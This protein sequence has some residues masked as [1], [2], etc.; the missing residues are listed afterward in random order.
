M[1]KSSIVLLS[2][3]LGGMLLASCSGNSSVDSV[4][5]TSTS[6]SASTSSEAG[7]DNVT[8]SEISSEASS[9][10]SAASSSSVQSGVNEGETSMDFQDDGKE[11]K[12]VELSDSVRSSVYKAGRN[13]FRSLGRRDRQYQQALNSAKY[14]NPMMQ[15]RGH[16]KMLVI[17]VYYSDSTKTAVQRESDRET[18]YKTF[19][20]GDSVSGDTYWESVRSYYYK[21]SY[22]QLS[23]EGAVAPSIRLPKT[24]ASYSAKTDW[25]VANTI[26]ET[27]YKYLFQGNNPVYSVSDFDGN[28]DGQIDGVY[29]VTDSPI[30]SGNGAPEIGWAFTAP[31]LNSNRHPIEALG[32]FAWS[33]QQFQV[34][35]GGSFAVPD[36]HTFIH[37][38]GHILGLNDLYDSN[39]KYDMSGCSN[40]Q[41]NNIC[42]HDPYSKYLW[43]WTQ[44]QLVTDKNTEDTISIELKPMEDT[45]D[46]LIIA[47][48]F[49]GTALDEY[50]M[51]EYY[52]PTGLNEADAKRKYESWQGI[53]GSGLRIWHVD[54]CV[55]VTKLVNTTD[56][57]GKPTVSSYFDPN[58]AETIETEG[59]GDDQ[60]IRAD[61]TCEFSDQDSKADYYSCFTT[62]SSTSSTSSSWD[63]TGADISYFYIRPELELLRATKVAGQNNPT[64]PS[65]YPTAADLFTA[66]EGKNSFGTA[67]DAY[68][69]FQFYNYATNVG[70]D[71]DDTTL[72]NTAR[73]QLPYTIH[74]DSIGETAKITLTK[75]ASSST[76]A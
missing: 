43:G 42:D 30:Q 70:Y 9:E 55:N 75:K 15:S 37:E 7:S 65:A 51:V 46:C 63:A 3:T 50:L 67:D 14:G 44:P 73:L 25:T 49:N 58:P 4:L 6:S 40:M 61:V 33:S 56:S 71:P 68:S 18:I 34:V 23:I 53:D 27:C 66:E 54:K 76:A 39:G 11:L 5:S 12:E 28:G 31:H 62:N 35:N 8:V 16:A 17:P 2:L 22:G 21:S 1:K 59:E 72:K 29:I 10:S 52:T 57:S 26:L 47:S 24:Y 20:G 38:T 60:T 13:I 41:T 45:G 69:D 64:S 19:F 48:S 32:K 74:V 36:A